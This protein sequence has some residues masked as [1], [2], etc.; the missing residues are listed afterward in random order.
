MKIGILGGGQLGRMLALSGYPLGL[1]FVFYEPTEGAPTSRIAPTIRGAF[2]ETAMLARFAAEVDVVT[3]ELEH[4]PLQAV[5]C[6]EPTR[7]VY[8]PPQALAIGQNRIREKTFFQSLG[9]P[10]PR[11]A[12]ITCSGDLAAALEQVGSPAVLKT[13]LQGYDGKGQRRVNSV[14]EATQA[15]VE[16]G[17]NELIAEEFISFEREVSIVAVRSRAGE[18]RFYPLVQNHHSSGI[19][20][21]TEAPAPALTPA[22]QL[23][24]ED[25]CQRI[26]NALDYVGVLTIE[27]FVRGGHLVANEMAPRV[28][29]S[30][31]WTIEGATTSQFENH[32]RAIAGLPLGTTT[33]REEWTMFNLIGGEPTPANFLD[34]PGAHLHL[35]GKSSKPGRKIG[36]VTVLRRDAAVVAKLIANELAAPQ[37]R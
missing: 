14:H 35:Y 1:D 10:T 7:P 19:L 16:L 29:N 17:G 27:F 20:I 21:R 3:Y 6:I 36:H 24:A 22:L 34:V 13:T 9:V 23:E 12:P 31:H 11:F 8:P 28:H 2:D 15:F 5:E 32:L 26:L 25:L 4:L 33:A 30:G 18:T 37:V